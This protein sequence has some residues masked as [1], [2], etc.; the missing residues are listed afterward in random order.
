MMVPDEPFCLDDEVKVV[1]G[2]VDVRHEDD[3]DELLLLKDGNADVCELIADVT[4]VI[5]GMR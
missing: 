5:I 4:D 2:Q 3:T 1:V